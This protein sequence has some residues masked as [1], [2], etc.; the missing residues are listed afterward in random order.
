MRIFLTE[1]IS[2]TSSLMTN[3]LGW[4]RTKT[5]LRR[6]IQE[7]WPSSC[8]ESTK[9]TFYVGE[10]PDGWGVNQVLR[11][12]NRRDS[13]QH[14]NCIMRDDVHQ[15]CDNLLLRATWDTAATSGNAALRACMINSVTILNGKALFIK[16][17]PYAFS[18]KE[19]YEAIGT[20]VQRHGKK[21]LLSC[22][23]TQLEGIKDINRRL[24]LTER[25]AKYL[26]D[27]SW[28][29]AQYE[30]L[31]ASFTLASSADSQRLGNLLKHSWNGDERFGMIIISRIKTQPGDNILDFL[32]QLQGANKLEIRGIFSHLMAL[33][34]EYLMPTNT[35]IVSSRHH[36][37][38]A[39]ILFACY[40]LELRLE[41]HRLVGK[42]LF[43]TQ[44]SSQ[45]Y[46][47]M[48]FLPLLQR[49]AQLIGNSEA[50]K[51]TQ[52]RD[53]CITVLD[54]SIIK[55]IPDPPS[56][57]VR[58]WSRQPLGC[59][60]DHYECETLDAFLMNEHAISSSFRFTVPVEEHLQKQITAEVRL[61]NL[62]HYHEQ[63]IVVTKID[64][65]TRTGSKIGRCK[66]AN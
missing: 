31:I 5:G 64:K 54:T 56:Q 42:L 50:L 59:G 66:A 15:I 21:W 3:R 37:C 11:N 35:Q 4:A 62:T 44:V 26:D 33:S 61:G 18:C 13:S 25:I 20:M 53:L 12:F 48:F 43:E 2:R 9:S 51:L 27:D 52:Y 24:V 19:A 39:K 57:G 22:L 17:L 65:I 1:T 32:A 58:N 6:H 10:K 29:H 45:P 49:L 14:S 38:L 8:L 60:L 28:I 7:Q 47:E 36:E 23:T 63:G 40:E 16:A 30:E 34:E 46:L 55:L 41:L